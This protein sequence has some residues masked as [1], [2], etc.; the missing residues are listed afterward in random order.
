M[1]TLDETG[2]NGMKT[3]EQDMPDWRILEWMFKSEAKIYLE[4]SK[5]M[6][7]YFKDHKGSSSYIEFP[8]GAREF[9]DVRDA[10]VKN[11]REEESK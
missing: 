1:K 8:K 4:G 2:P 6:R 10:V 5:P 9:E 11:I 3:E 7:L